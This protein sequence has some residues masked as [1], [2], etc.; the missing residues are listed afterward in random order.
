M[1]TKHLLINR[2]F[3][4]ATVF[5]AVNLVLSSTSF[6]QNNEVY[7][8]NE[9]ELGKPFEQTRTQDPLVAC[10]VNPSTENCAQ[11]SPSLSD[12]Q[13]ESSVPSG[14]LEATVFLF[15]ASGKVAEKPADDMHGSGDAKAISISV[16]FDYNSSTI[17]STEYFKLGQIARALTSPAT[18]NIYF[19]LVGH[20][21]AKGSRE[22]NCQLS[23]RRASS[24]KTF[25]LNQGV[26]TFRMISI[27]A[28]EG[29]LKAGIDPNSPRN[30]RVGFLKL[31]DSS[32]EV[33]KAISE[34]CRE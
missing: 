6:A 7:I 10:F 27:G 28:G 3:R 23:K 8:A 33:L 9:I 4:L 2:L 1:N 32:D 5:T 34:I 24:V 19:A 31:G 14:T 25:L 26:D 21:D 22:Y 16:E 13:Y 18:R 11:A 17:R 30:R 29:L 12:P 20:T 15:D